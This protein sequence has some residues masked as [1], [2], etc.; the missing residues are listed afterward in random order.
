MKFPGEITQE[1]STVH[2]GPRTELKGMLTFKYQE[3]KDDPVKE[4]SK[5]RKKTPRKAKGNKKMCAGHRCQE[6]EQ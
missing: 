1:E 2:R 5:K 3:V 6:F 4:N